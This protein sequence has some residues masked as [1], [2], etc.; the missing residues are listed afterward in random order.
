MKPSSA[1]LARLAGLDEL[2]DDLR[3]VA[4]G[5]VSDALN[6]PLW[7]AERT[8]TLTVHQVPVARPSIETIDPVTGPAAF[9]PDQ[10]GVSFGAV[11]FL[12]AYPVTSVAAPG[13]L[14]DKLSAW[15]P[16]QPGDRVEVT[17]TGGWDTDSAPTDV[18]LA[19]ANLCATL[20][21][22]AAP[23]IPE[24]LAALLAAGANRVAVADQQIGFAGTGSLA[25]RNRATQAEEIARILN[26]I[27]HHRWSLG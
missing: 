12:P 8:A 6:R 10:F 13:A 17:Y 27:R 15:W 20:T 9:D 16:G 14:R 3:K 11:V 21:P 2:D 25:T 23:A 7:V 5:L 22:S 24:D 1:L 4:E 26:G 19:V 18:L